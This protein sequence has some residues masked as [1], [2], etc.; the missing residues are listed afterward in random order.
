MRCARG[1]PEP[2]TGPD[3]QCECARGHRPDDERPALGAR[4][5]GAGRRLRDGFPASQ[6]GDERTEDADRGTDAEH[7]WQA[8]PHAR[9]GPGRDG[10]EREGA[11]E[12]EDHR[13]ERRSAALEDAGTRGDRDHEDAHQHEQRDL[14][15]G[16]EQG[17]HQVLRAGGGQV[18]D[19][20]ADRHE[21]AAG[22]TEEQGGEF[23]GGEEGQGGDDAGGRGQQSRPHR[24]SAG[25]HGTIVRPVVWDPAASGVRVHRG[26]VPLR[27]WSC[28]DQGVL[29]R[30]DRVPRDP[31]ARRPMSPDARLLTV[32]WIV[33]G[34]GQHCSS[35]A[36]S[37]WRAARRRT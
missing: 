26:A 21:R 34:S 17:D 33:V 18:D 5:V 13:A 23:G 29:R 19:R 4:C 11:A 8:V 25:G 37:S 27:R 9:P 20:A 22:S 35:R 2:R 12:C 30:R 14:V 36:W 1:R 16:T 7:R 6:P 10:D 15:A 3:H 32:R 28:E 24:R 31:H